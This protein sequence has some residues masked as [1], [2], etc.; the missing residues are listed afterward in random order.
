MTATTTFA[1]RRILGESAL[2]IASVYLA[3]VLEGY[4]ADRSNVKQAR[5]ALTQVRADLANDKASLPVVLADQR[6]LTEVYQNLAKWLLEP[7]PESN[8]E[9][10]EALAELGLSN[11]TVF[12]LKGAWTSMLSSGQLT[13]LNAPALTARLGNLYGNINDRLEYNGRDY[14]YSLNEVTRVTVSS[15][16]DKHHA[17]PIGDLT[18]LRNELQYLQFVWND[19]YI[20]LLLEY[21]QEL[22]G[23]IADIDNYLAS[24]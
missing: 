22:E 2:I 24:H 12:P 11:R 6:A 9:L 16:W 10:A 13:W 21:E 15:V 23:V 18:I 1:W 17:R 3:I 20:D 19:F 4:S 5:A 7:N 8:P 14:D